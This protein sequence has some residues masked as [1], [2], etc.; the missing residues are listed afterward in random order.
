MAKQ[1]NLAYVTLFFRNRISRHTIANT[2]CARFYNTHKNKRFKQKRWLPP[3][4]THLRASP[5]RQSRRPRRDSTTTNSK[6]RS[7]E[8]LPFINKNPP[9]PPLPRSRYRR[10]FNLKIKSSR[11]KR[12]HTRSSFARKATKGEAR[13]R[14]KCRS[15]T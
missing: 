12:E 11:R 8:A 5:R 4:R 15:L 3:A 7:F 1:N 14:R 13:R 10:R 9:P 6:E 2:V